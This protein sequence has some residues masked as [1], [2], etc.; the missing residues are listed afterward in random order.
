MIDMENNLFNK[1]K[2]K[3]AEAC[4]TIEGEFK[5]TKEGA[6]CK[7]EYTVEKEGRVTKFG[8][9][10]ILDTT[11][12]HRLRGKPTIN[13]LVTSRHREKGRDLINVD[14]VDK[15]FGMG[16]PKSIESMEIS[17]YPPEG[18]IEIETEDGF[19]ANI[20]KGE[21]TLGASS[22]ERIN[23]QIF[24]NGNCVFDSMIA[25]WKHFQPLRNP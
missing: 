3:L 25:N 12:F 16:V 22:E 24:K 17:P 9:D 7:K 23:I 20:W 10:I 13:I 18:R 8:M 19:K 5:V 11:E 6:I 21:G 2:E 4:K 15:R 14:A 1:F